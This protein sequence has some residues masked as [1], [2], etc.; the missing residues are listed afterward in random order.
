M[1]QVGLISIIIPTH[2]R[3]EALAE[4][5]TRLAPN[6]QTWPA[7]QYEVIVTDDGSTITAEA[8]IRERFP[9]ARWTAGPRRG[10]AA[11]RNHGALLGAGDWLAFV[12][13][14]CQPSAGWLSALAAVAG[15]HH[16]FVL[17]GRTTCDAGI[18]PL[19]EEAPIN[20]NGGN[21]WSCNM[22]VQRA[23]FE[24]VGM[25]DERFMFSAEDVEFHDRVRR[26]GIT[27][28]F[29]PNAVVDHP[30]RPR[31]RG[32]SAGRLWEGR[33]LLRTL[34]SN[35]LIGWMPLHVAKLRLSQMFA[36]RPTWRWCSFAWSSALEVATVLLLHR[37]WLRLHAGATPITP[38][39]YANRA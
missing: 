14:D 4:C 5:L 2:H 25:F 28:C 39:R 23:T 32:F 37:R 26:A 11:N 16:C 13:D 29:V 35:T 36:T 27:A 9:W 34:D 38:E 10:P 18:R 31:R 6:V 8:M 22:A 21:L 12:D 20:L 1:R 15:E 19:V 33:A 3:I 24:Q 7:T 17:E 30:P